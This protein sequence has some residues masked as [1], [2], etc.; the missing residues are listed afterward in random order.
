MRR[1][2]VAATIVVCGMLLLVNF[3]VINPTLAA[4]STV[5]L[6]LIVL[7]AASA[8]LA[9]GLALA[10]RHLRVL[11][12]PGPDRRGSG[13]L[14]LGLIAMLAAGFYPGS[15]GTGDPAV[16]WLVAA[17]LAPLVASIFAL[18]F[19]FLL[20]AAGRGL[21][22]HPRETTLMLAA[23]V[24][25]IVLLLPVGGGAGDWLSGSAR[26]AQ[27][28]PIGAVFRGLLIGIGLA[29]AVHAGRILLSV[30]APRD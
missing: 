28:F 27:E 13:V 5:L 1:S 12:S 30:D 2:L 6:E 10:V 7:L 24:V 20:R 19:V 26:W 22:V 11:A 29:T 25:V 8:A 4:A 3:V 15:G 14:L 9:G 16:R 21:R 23:A 17:L 18:L